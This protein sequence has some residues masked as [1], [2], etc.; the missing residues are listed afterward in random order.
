MQYDRHLNK[1]HRKMKTQVFQLF[2]EILVYI[3]DM[4]HDRCAALYELR[5]ILRA[6]LS[7]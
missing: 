4:A 2:P 7:F 5:H 6:S 1:R 3:G